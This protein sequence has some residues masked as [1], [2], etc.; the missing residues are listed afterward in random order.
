MPNCHSCGLAFTSRS[1]LAKH[2]SSCSP[3]FSSSASQSPFTALYALIVNCWNFLW[4]L[5]Y[6]GKGASLLSWAFCIGV[7]WPLTGYFLWNFTWAPLRCI[8]IVA[9]N[10]ARLIWGIYAQLGVFDE[11]VAVPVPGNETLSNTTSNGTTFDGFDPQSPRVR[12]IKTFAA[13]TIDRI[14]GYCADAI[15]GTPPA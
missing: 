14:A 12:I 13:S 7:V 2:R 4:V 6:P 15:Y 8:L 1:S 5:C 10:I 11:F 3:V 9:M